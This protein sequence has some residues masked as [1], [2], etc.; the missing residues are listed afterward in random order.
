MLLNSSRAQKNRKAELKDWL[1]VVELWEDR[2]QS[3]PS[4][5][6]DET[7]STLANMLRSLEESKDLI[8]QAVRTKLRDSRAASDRHGLLSFPLP[9][10][11]RPILGRSYEGTRGGGSEDAEV[12][13]RESRATGRGR[14]FAAARHASTMAA[15]K[16]RGK[17]IAISTAAVGIV[18]LVGWAFA[19]QDRLWE[20][21]YL[22]RLHSY[23]KDARLQ[24]ID[25]LADR[26][27]LRAARLFLQSLLEDW[28]QIP[29]RRAFLRMRNP[30][31]TALLE[32]FRETKRADEKER[33]VSYLE[34][35]H[36]PPPSP[37]WTCRIPDE[38]TTIVLTRI[39]SDHANSTPARKLA[40]EALNDWMASR[41]LP[42]RSSP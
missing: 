37:G 5:S 22:I 38:A 28:K 12:R 20:E 10:C 27:S 29:L 7:T 41:A 2:R 14:R 1:A 32:R 23:D 19:A 24:A 17:A 31:T 13:G 35:L 9:P 36:P 25:A 33:C 4:V 40:E 3:Q 11:G 42:P 18:V 8:G 30:A 26:N 21:Y 15:V 34:Q 6:L 39:V 16:R